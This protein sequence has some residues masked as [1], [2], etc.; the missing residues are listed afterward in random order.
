MKG[1]KTEEDFI[2]LEYKLFL[3]TIVSILRFV[4]IIPCL[5]KIPSQFTAV[6]SRMFQ[7]GPTAR[8]V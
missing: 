6:N 5:Y 2:L 3:E 4:G 8:A 7:I 1:K